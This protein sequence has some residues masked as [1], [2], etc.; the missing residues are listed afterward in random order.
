MTTP[1][2][3]FDRNCNLGWEKLESDEAKHIRGSGW[4]NFSRMIRR[5][6]GNK[7]QVCGIEKNLEVHHILD[8]RHFRHLRFERSN[9][10]VLCQYHHGKSECGEISR[11]TLIQ[12]LKEY[13]MSEWLT[14]PDRQPGDKILRQLDLSFVE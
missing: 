5:E 7:C 6:R 3:R 1:H 2:Y 14:T 10:I 4:P 9:V 13:L 8:V 12:L 11:D